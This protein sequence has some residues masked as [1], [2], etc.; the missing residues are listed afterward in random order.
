MYQVVKYEE[1]EKI[2]DNNYYAIYLNGK[3]NGDE[4]IELSFPG[5]QLIDALSFHFDSSI[6]KADKLDYSFGVFI[7]MM[8]ALADIVLSKKAKIEKNGKLPKED[9]E[10]LLIATL[11]KV[12]LIDEVNTNVDYKIDEI[13]ERINKK[14]K[15]YAKDSQLFNSIKN[16]FSFKSLIVFSLLK[17]NNYD[18]DVEA[19][20]NQIRKIEDEDW[21]K[22]PWPIK[23]SLSFVEWLLNQAEDYYKTHK[24]RYDDEDIINIPQ[25]RDALENLIK[26]LSLSKLFSK[27]EFDIK[28]FLSY[29]TNFLIEEQDKDNTFTEDLFGH[30][31][32]V[33]IRK[34]LVKTYLI[35]KELVKT[36][37]KKKVSSIEG[38][39][40]IDLHSIINKNKRVKAS[41]DSVSATIA[42]ASNG[43]FATAKGIT[44]EGDTLANIAS[45]INIP[46]MLD[47][48]SV[49]RV[50]SKYIRDDL[51]KGKRD[52]KY[53]DEYIKKMNRID[54]EMFSLNKVETRILYSLQLQIIQNDIDNTKDSN[55]QIKKHDWLVR[56]KELSIESIGIKKLFEEDEE[57]VYK[58]IANH[59]ETDKRNIWLYL[60]ALELELFK[61]YFPLEKDEK[62]VVKIFKSTYLNDVFFNKQNTIS[63]EDYKLLSGYYSKYKNELNG[64]NKKALAAVGAL[65]VTV[66]G[67]VA[68]F[69]FAPAIAVALVGGTFQGL[70]GAALASASLALLGGGSLAV[71]GL[72][73][74]GGTFVIAGGGA[75][76]SLGTSGSTLLTLMLL[77]SSEYTVK[78][79]AKLL[80]KC[81]FILEK[82]GT[83]EEVEIIHNALE[84]NIKRITLERD[85]MLEKCK[86][87]ENFDKMM[88][89]PLKEISKSIKV[90][91]HAN[92]CLKK[93]IKNHKK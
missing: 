21:S 60:I 88:K 51:E 73:M 93:I 91:E 22:L 24:I 9:A 36:I 69:V 47:M 26:Q 80:A 52:K 83:K 87:D 66:L 8:A 79:Y 6:N 40:L 39:L 49:L 65:V 67:T 5:T 48:V 11:K 13:I 90:S 58:L 2:L 74:A 28:A 50:D 19:K 20:T 89:K 59:A 30:F 53:V 10:K 18:V 37:Y 85:L 27:E 33:G 29:F 44:E 81:R 57:T 63:K 35:L 61:P 3:Q 62:P 7:G 71:G 46:G 56:W 23:L 25:A 77:T 14:A 15:V 4:D 16:N 72:G 54:S 45:Y 43:V 92:E 34:V 86:R 38:I 82:F 78:D 41:M 31:S 12:Q 42:V 75:L 70:H 17:V 32:S 55:M 84:E 68:A 1:N 76:L 64:G